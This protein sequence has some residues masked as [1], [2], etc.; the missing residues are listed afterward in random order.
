MRVMSYKPMIRALYD[1]FARGDIETILAALADDVVW[2]A[3][4]GAPYSGRRF[5]R[6][7]VRQ[8]LAA[9]DRLVRIDE[10]DADEVLEDGDYVVVL[11]RERATV[12]ESGRHF[13][14]AFAHLYKLRG[15]K[16]AEVRLFSDTNAA[17]SAF[18]ESIAER[19]ALGG[20]LGVTHEAFSGDPEK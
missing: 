9:V 11:G 10:F 14:T 1:A 13:E 20:P 19:K 6:A 8:Y 17:A 18:G 4:G 2:D 16:V 3:P 12:K 15:G 5:G 7:G